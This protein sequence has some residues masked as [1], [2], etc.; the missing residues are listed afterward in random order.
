MSRFHNYSF[1]KASSNQQK[2]YE[3]EQ[4]RREKQRKARVA[5]FERITEQAPSV[6]TATQ[7]PF[8]TP[9]DRLHGPV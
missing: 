4:G 1:G 6:F 5:T 2:E 8:V 7:I 9:T 3:A